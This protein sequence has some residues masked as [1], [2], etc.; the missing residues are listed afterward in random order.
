[1]AAQGDNNGSRDR[2]EQLA[3]ARAE[4]QRRDR[5]RK[6]LLGTGVGVLALAL[7]GG[8]AWIGHSKGGQHSGPAASISA[9]APVWGGLTGQTVDGVAADT[10]EHLAYHTH[11]HLAI[12]LDGTALTVPAGVGITTP[13]ESQTQ[14]DGSIWIAS[15][16]HF[17]YLHT[18]TTDGIIHMESP[19]DAAYR[20]GQFFAEWNQPL[21]AGRV[22]P[23]KGTVTTY[24]NGARYDGDP[25]GITLAPHTVIQLDIGQDV[26]PVPYTFAAGL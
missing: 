18:H 22:G 1:M 8:F 7:A 3:R 17:Y 23:D 16:S 13:W 9:L 12:Y 10:I 26:A 4:E 24:V 25:A 6:I 15:G 20:L 21:S 5:T 19:T 11:A 14:P 2:R